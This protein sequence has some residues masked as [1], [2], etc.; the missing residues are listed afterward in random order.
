MLKG[1]GFISPSGHKPVGS[2]SGRG[3]GRQLIHVSLISM[4]LFLFSLFDT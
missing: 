1:Y 2:I 4:F 3:L